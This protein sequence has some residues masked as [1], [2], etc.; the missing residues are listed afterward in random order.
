MI[1]LRVTHL[2]YEIQMTEKKEEERKG[3]PKPTIAPGTRANCHQC[4]TLCEVTNHSTF[5]TIPMKRLQLR[6]TLKVT[7]VLTGASTTTY[8][9]KKGVSVQ[10]D[11]G[12]R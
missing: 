12:A 11:R 10:L 4:H 6:N 3:K 1:P 8:P 7:V 9:A 5:K 2:V